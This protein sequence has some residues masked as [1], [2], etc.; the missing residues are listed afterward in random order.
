MSPAVADLD[1]DGDMEI[2]VPSH[3]VLVLDHQGNLVATGI[4][5]PHWARATPALY[6][7][8]GNG[9]LEII[10]VS[11]RFL[12]DIG[13]RNELY[14]WDRNGNLVWKH[15]L[16]PQDL[17]DNGHTD[18]DYNRDN[19]LDDTGVCISVYDARYLAPIPDA[20]T[21]SSETPNC[22]EIWQIGQDGYIEWPRT[23]PTVGD[24]DGDSVPEVVLAVSIQYTDHVRYDANSEYPDG[25]F[26]H[27]PGNPEL[28]VA[29]NRG[30]VG[31]Y[32]DGLIYAWNTDGSLVD[33]FPFYDHYIIGTSP[34]LG[35]VDG[36]GV[37]DIVVG[38]DADR[39][40]AI[41]GDGSVIPAWGHILQ[42]RGNTADL[43]PTVADLNSDGRMEVLFT[44]ANNP[45]YTNPNHTTGLH[46]F[47]SY[48]ETMAGTPLE[49]LRNY[50]SEID[51]T[52]PYWPAITP[53]AVDV[54]GDDQVEIISAGFDKR[55]HFL[56]WDGFQLSERPGWPVSLGD[57]MGSEPVVADFDGDG[58]AEILI[59]I[60]DHKKQTNGTG[61]FLVFELDGSL[62]TDLSVQNLAEGVKGPAALGDINNDGTL[63]IVASDETGNVRAYSTGAG[64]PA[65]IL[66]SQHQHDAAHTGRTPHASYQPGG[67][68]ATV[69]ASSAR[70]TWQAVP[71][72]AG[73]HLY[74][75]TPE[76]PIW[77][78][79]TTPGAPLTTTSFQDDWIDLGVRYLYQV[80]SVD[81]AELRMGLSEP[82]AVDVSPP[83]NLITNPGFESFLDHWDYLRWTV[84]TAYTYTTVAGAGWNGGR[85]LEVQSVVS[86]TASFTHLRQYYPHH[87]PLADRYLSLEAGQL[88]AFGAF[89][90]IEGYSS[91]HRWRM[92]LADADYGGAVLFYTDRLWDNSDGWIYVSRIF[93]AP[94]DLPRAQVRVRVQPSVSD[95]G[96]TW[97][98]DVLLRPKATDMTPVVPAGSVWRYND[99]GVDLGTI[100]RE[101]GYDDS[102]WPSGPAELGFGDGD[103]ATVLTNTYNSTYY[104]RRTFTMPNAAVEDAT[105]WVNYDDGFSA[106]LNGELVARSQN[107]PPL[108]DPPY[109][110]YTSQSPFW[111]DER[112]KEGGTFEPYDLSPFIKLFQPDLNLL[113]VE[114]H[115]YRSGDPDSVRDISF[116]ARLDVKLAPSPTPT[117]TPTPT[118]TGTPPTATPT[119]TSTPTSTGTPTSTPTLTPTAT[120]VTP[121]VAT[122]P[123]LN[124]LDDTYVRVSSGYNQEDV[125]QVWLGHSSGYELFS[126]FR[127]DNVTIPQGSQ[128]VSASLRLYYSWQTSTDILLHFYAEA[129]DSAL[130]FRDSNPLAHQRPRTSATVSWHITDYLPSG[131]ISPPDVT[132]LVQEVV[133]RPGWQAG[134]ALA[135][136]V[137]SDTSNTGYLAVVAR[138]ESPPTGEQYAARLSIAYR[139]CAGATDLNCDGQVDIN[140]IAMIAA[141]WSTV[142]PELSQDGDDDVDIV[143][144]QMVAATWGTP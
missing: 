92:D 6:D 17:D 66:W 27:S 65:S 46:L 25:R 31:D 39:M 138:D 44:T 139:A 24:I 95:M 144:V 20:G 127:F 90:N 49:F 120:P 70:L 116:D 100:W 15:S 76:D 30:N 13:A 4:V 91:N 47:D 109:D 124:G 73:Y 32:Y 122:Y 143:D 72:A 131:W 103:E 36:D 75:R 85:A 134:N 128:I 8:D 137:Q 107:M 98:D 62:R 111:P 19:C 10:A 59:T 40:Y 130:D 102:S 136:L 77:I 79:L 54:D 26:C 118:W 35:D 60:Y 94:T 58:E 141:A 110:W 86:T 115:Q 78:M 88:Y 129:S 64:D 117:P 12:P 14:V 51:N 133:D 3:D 126:G 34:A 9:D 7:L 55:L 18:V 45:L 16:N 114:V 105:L 23:A 67:L 41:R 2:V 61:G 87:I 63:D 80:E 69:T 132:E 96:T 38:N 74:R 37:L 52:L 125:A 82:L 112:P 71:S 33:G 56:D 113:A 121:V 21:D 28:P 93:T 104:F 1:G 81:S 135:I 119:P 11:E 84:P 101:P 97:F 48:G 108:H 83:G 123:V 142:N 22:Q 68:S 5:D 53:I 50:Y 57:H 42:V 43:N 89:L 140:D 99:Q 29:A 106:Y